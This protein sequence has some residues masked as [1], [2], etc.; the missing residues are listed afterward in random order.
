VAVYSGEWLLLT[1]GLN[2]PEHLFGASRWGLLNGMLWQLFTYPLLH[3]LQSPWPIVLTVAGLMLAGRELEGILGARHFVGLAATASAAGAMA[4]AFASPAQL[5]LGAL[6]AV[7]ALVLACTTI[8]PEC[9]LW[10]PVRTRLRVPYKYLGW[11]LVLTL[12]IFCWREQAISTH[13][14]P[15][16]NLLGAVTGWAYARYLGFGSPWRL[17]QCWRDRRNRDLRFERM[18]CDQFMREQVDPVL[19]KIG[20]EG[21]KSLTRAERAILQR[22]RQK[23][24]DK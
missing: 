14:S 5:L 23:L 7:C 21:L 15:W 16:A 11:A 2:C 4:H 18:S 24:F 1:A 22:A 3:E 10:F 6:P 9:P 17:E 20:R 8:L 19:E 12:V 13:S